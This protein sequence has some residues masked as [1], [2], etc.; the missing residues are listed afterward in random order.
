VRIGL[1]VAGGLDRSGRERVLPELLDFIERIARRHELHAFAL[2]YYAQPCDYELRGA[3]VHDLGRVDRPRG[4]RVWRMR[5]RL[6]AAID[7]AGRFDLL[8]AYWGMPTGAVAVD[9]GAAAGIPVVVTLTTGEL[10]AM[11]DIEYGL[12]RRRRDRAAVDRIF[13]RAAQV[14]VPTDYMRR[15]AG[16]HANRLVVMPMGLDRGRFAPADVAEG[17]PWRLLRVATINRVKDYPLLLRAFALVGAAAPDTH[18]DIVGEDVLGGSMQA[19]AR[20]L[21]LSARVTFHGYQPMDR[22]PA[23][24]ARAHLHVVSSRHEASSVTALEASLAG[25]PTVGTAVGHLADWAALSP[26]AAMTIAQHDPQGLADAIIA[27]L[28]NPPRRRQLAA[29]A[30]TWA[31]TH[32][33]DSTAAAFEQLYARVAA[34]ATS[35]FR[36]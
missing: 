26:P 25:V 30:R 1:I 35:T 29:A 3:W 12:Q 24:Y 27:L 20:E 2:Q 22:L 10:V 6:Q 33:A 28:R 34:G 8:H 11:D 16:R 21:G 15:L 19:L 36:R 7:G 23:F 32:D 13:D 5:R 17:P 4:L 18:L 31:L 14:T 9:V